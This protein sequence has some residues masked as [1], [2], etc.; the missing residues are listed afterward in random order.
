M[1]NNQRDHRREMDRTP[2]NEHAY[3][4]Y[5]EWLRREYRLVLR[6]ALSH[7]DVLDLLPEDI[8]IEFN[9]SIRDT[10]GSHVEYAPLHDR[11]VRVHISLFDAYFL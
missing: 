7:E 4:T 5:L 10:H 1:W 3:S 2:D 11:V 9:N 6:G 8:D